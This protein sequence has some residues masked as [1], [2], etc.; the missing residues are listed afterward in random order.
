M[1]GA[2][3]ALLRLLRQDAGLE[4]S[5]GS[6]PARHSEACFAIQGL[7]R[8]PGAVS[9]ERRAVAEISELTTIVDCGWPVPRHVERSRC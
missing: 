3:P 4:M 2:L 6:I 1:G 8:L 7:L 9:D 5:I